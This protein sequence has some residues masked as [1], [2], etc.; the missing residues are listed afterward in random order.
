MVFY[1]AR[2]RQPYGTVP[3]PARACIG[4]AAKALIDDIYKWC[5]GPSL[6]SSRL[7]RAAYQQPHLQAR[8]SISASH[9]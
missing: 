8:T 3:F 6:A 7:R 2:Q 9:A 1:E 4:I 5:D